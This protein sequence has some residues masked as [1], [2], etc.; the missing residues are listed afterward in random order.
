MFWISLS[1]HDDVHQLICITVS[2]SF[3][4]YCAVALLLSFLFYSNLQPYWDYLSTSV[5]QF[6]AILFRAL[7]MKEFFLKA[8][9]S[10]LIKK[11]IQ[12]KKQRGCEIMKDWR[13]ETKQAGWQGNTLQTR[14]S[15]L[16]LPSIQI[17]VPFDNNCIT[18]QIKLYNMY[19]YTMLRIQHNI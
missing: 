2:C 19:M 1:Y 11:P 4:T 16:S 6:Y 13:K 18:L 3:S 10:L 17:Y 15:L 8:K 14:Q 9:T 12:W 5:Y 7:L